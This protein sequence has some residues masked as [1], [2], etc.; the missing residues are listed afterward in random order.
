[1]SIFYFQ[2]G[3]F[4]GTPLEGQEC[5]PQGLGY[6]EDAAEH[7]QMTAVLRTSLQGGDSPSSVLPGLRTRT[8]ATRGIFTDIYSELQIMLICRSKV[9]SSCLF[10]RPYSTFVC[11]K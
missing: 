4:A 10:S 5:Q 3:K 8:R 11:C 9:D 2:S 7:E 1:M 6:T